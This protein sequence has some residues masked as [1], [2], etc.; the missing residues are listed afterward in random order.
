LRLDL[1]NDRACGQPLVTDSCDTAVTL[2]VGRHP[3]SV[4]ASKRSFEANRRNRVCRVLDRTTF[5]W[6]KIMR[7]FSF[8]LLLTALVAGVG[9]GIAG[10]SSSEP[11]ASGKMGSEKMSTDNT[12]ADKMGSDK[13]GDGKMGSDKMGSDKMS[14]D[15]MGSGKMGTDKMGSDKMGDGK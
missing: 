1:P 13:M 3:K 14:S 7:R 12:G 10:C 8:G 15:K 4:A 9:L 5:G 6:E 2:R 11:A